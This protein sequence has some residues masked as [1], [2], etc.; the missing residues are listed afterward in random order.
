MIGTM[1]SFL[2]YLGLLILVALQ[3]GGELLVSQRN[4]RRME[5][6][7]GVEAGADSYPWMVLLHASF[8]VSCGLEVWLLRRPLVPPL[9]IVMLVVLAAA[10]ALRVWVLMTLGELWCTRVVYVP[11]QPLVTGGP[12]R[13]LRHPNYLAVGLELAALPLVHTAYLTALVYG[14]ANALVLRRRIAIEEAALSR[15]CRYQE[16]FAGHR[17]LLPR[18][19]R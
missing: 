13:W 17:R 6:R 15:D 14:A 1:D 2:P 12:Y 19:P 11:G 5:S 8:L 7:G 18:R 4:R 10:S 16:L 3:R 9:A